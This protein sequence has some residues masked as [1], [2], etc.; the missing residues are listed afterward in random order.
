MTS[1]DFGWKIPSMHEIIN[2]NK[3]TDMSSSNT[4]NN[5]NNRI[6]IFEEDDEEISEVS[7][8]TSILLEGMKNKN[9]KKEN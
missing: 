6:A 8:L 2:N 3:N 5:N 7:V 9:I 1:Y 4:K